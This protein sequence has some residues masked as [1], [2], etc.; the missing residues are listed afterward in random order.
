MTTVVPRPESDDLP[1]QT[2]ASTLVSVPPGLSTTLDSSSWAAAKREPVASW[3]R[4]FVRQLLVTDAVSAVVATALGWLIRFGF[5]TDVLTVSYLFWSGFITLGWLLSLHAAGAYEI[6][7]ISTGAR[8]YQRV[9]RGSMNLIGAVAVIGYLTGILLARTFVAIVIP[10]GALLMLVARYIGRQAVH[11]RRKR[12]HWTSA[13]LAVGTSESVRHLA[14]VTSRNPEA[15]LVV[16]GACVED[17]EAGDEVAHGVPVVGEVSKAAALAEELGVDI[18]AVAGSGLGP[19][20]IRELGWALEGTG[21]NMVMAPGLTEVAGPRVHVSPVEGLPLMWVDQPQFTGLR[22]LVKRGVDVLGAAIILAAVAPLLLVIA[23]LVRVT[24]RGPILYRSLRMGQEGCQIKVYKFR[25]M[26]RDADARRADLLQLNE[27]EGGMLFK[28]RCDPRVTPVGRLLRKFSIDEL[29]QLFNV[30]G[31][32]MSLVGPRPPLPDE[33]ERYHT[34]MHRRL[35][36]KPGMT[37]LWQ[38]SGRSDL[39]WDESVRLDLYYVENWSLA[40]D[41]AIIART[42]WAVLQGRGAY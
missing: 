42:V 21:R 37:G 24:S 25:S 11:A 12:G 3:S 4:T 18:V 39:S 38:V 32:S 6:R 20:R 27:S 8:E 17:A 19:R 41:L 30:L 23:V 5:G 36:V 31:G 1:G 16:V 26:Y 29:P 34:H 40:L 33:V 15:G 7:R 35:L 28:M 2:L 9:L 13:I 14:E 22:R 10:L